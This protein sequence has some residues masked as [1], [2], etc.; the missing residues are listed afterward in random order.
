MDYLNNINLIKNIKNINPSKDSTFFL[1]PYMI[2]K[3]LDNSFL[4]FLLYKQYIHSRELCSF[5]YIHFNKS[6]E[7]TINAIKNVLLFIKEKN[8]FKGAIQDGNNFYLFYECECNNKIY[9]YNSHSYFLWTTVYEI[10]HFQSIFN[11]PIHYSTFT[12]FY[13]FQNCLTIG[14]YSIP[15]IIY[16]SKNINNIFENYSS[17][18]YFLKHE[19]NVINFTIRCIL[20]PKNDSFSNIQNHTFKFKNM[21]DLQII[22]E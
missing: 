9:N 20:F 11:I 16:T 8:Y 4:T 12:M 14:N 7:H 2:H 6:K 10:V 5:L 18:Y 1:C 17:G 3:H 13:K 21:N 19:P 15:Y 22:S